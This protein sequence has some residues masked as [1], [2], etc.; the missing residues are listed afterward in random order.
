MTEQ[1][2]IDEMARIA[3]KCITSWLNNETPKT[4]PDYIAEALYTEGYRRQGENTDEVRHGHWLRYGQDE[5]QCSLCGAVN[6][7]CI[8]NNYCP[9]CGARMKRR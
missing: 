8:N 2:Q 1:N 7:N 5:L 6:N 3:S 4:L 9:N